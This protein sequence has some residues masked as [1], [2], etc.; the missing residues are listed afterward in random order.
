MD[1]DTTR[2]SG[3]SFNTRGM[4]EMVFGDIITIVVYPKLVKR[5]NVAA[6]LITELSIKK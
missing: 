6:L 4:Y 5:E 1:H 3:D 2:V